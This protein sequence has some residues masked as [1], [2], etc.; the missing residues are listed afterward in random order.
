MNRYTI[1]GATTVK[2]NTVEDIRK[3]TIELLNEVMKENSLEIKD[4][5][6]II[7]T[8]TEDVDAVYPA[9]FAREIGF[10]EISLLC[11]QEM[12]VQGSLKKCIRILIFLRNNVKLKDV[13]NIYL[14]EAKNLRKDID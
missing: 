12:K 2:E 6:S 5:E 9:K 13:C 1:R 11:M 8:C 3:N 14:N 4:V 10:T 7:F